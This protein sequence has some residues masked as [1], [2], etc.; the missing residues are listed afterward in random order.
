MYHVKNISLQNKIMGV[1][2]TN[3]LWYQVRNW[4]EHLKLVSLQ[5]KS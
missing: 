3:Y 4:W 5:N 2:N 1:D